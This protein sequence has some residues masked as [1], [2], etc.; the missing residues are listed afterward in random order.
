[1]KNRVKRSVKMSC[2]DSFACSADRCPFTCCMQWK[3]SVDSDTKAL[4]KKMGLSDMVTKKDGTDVIRLNEN[5]FCPKLDNRKLCSLV[6]S[7]GDSSIPHTCRIFPRQIHEFSDRIE[8][9]LVNSCPEV[10]DLFYQGKSV[11]DDVQCKKGAGFMEYLRSFM[12][13]QI[14]DC[15][16]SVEENLKMLF[17][18]LLDLLKVKRLQNLA[19]DERKAQIPE[20]LLAIRGVFADSFERFQ[21]NGD[22]FL[23]MVVNYQKEGMYEAEL[24]PIIEAAEHWSEEEEDVVS[25][26]W[27]EFETQWQKY[28]SF[29]RRFLQG[30]MFANVLLPGNALED[31]IVLTEWMLLEYALIR[32]AVFYAWNL[33][34]KG[35][36]KYETV[37]TYA[38]VLSRMTGYDQ[39]DIY[40]YLE[41][42]FDD[43]IWEWG[44]VN[45]LL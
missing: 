34:G 33:Q 9:A 30:E 19:V 37:R 27:E 29:F 41:N 20:L 16:A 25:A 7:H 32:Q 44:Y 38:L 6:I 40:E 11:L 12:M 31:F 1:M 23:D 2:Y 10:L 17:F 39:E 28:E 8:Y 15:T 3:I 18:I 26:V 24:T 14:E 22:W 45:L 4:W 35:E 21:E 43:I 13:E 5:R 36:L 42:S